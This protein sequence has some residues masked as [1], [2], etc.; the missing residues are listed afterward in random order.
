M[1]LLWNF[2]I[3]ALLVGLASVLG[4]KMFSWVAPS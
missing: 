1:V 2:G 3:A 4:K